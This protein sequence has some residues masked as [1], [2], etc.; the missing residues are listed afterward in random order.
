MTGID[1]IWTYRVR[2]IAIRQRRGGEAGLARGYRLGYGSSLRRAASG[3]V[4][5]SGRLWARRAALGA[6]GRRRAAVSRRSSRF[7]ALGLDLAQLWV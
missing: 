6:G 2:R 7:G 3:S 5:G 1:P 4:R